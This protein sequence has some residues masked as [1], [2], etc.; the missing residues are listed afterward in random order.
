MKK[1][2]KS[3][4]I[5]NENTWKETEFRL[6]KTGDIFTFDKNETFTASCD[7]YVLPNEGMYSVLVINKELES[8]HQKRK[9][10]MEKNYLF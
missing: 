9:E 10:E 3:V 6:L 4:F 5:L 1:I 2:Q 7:A 8:F